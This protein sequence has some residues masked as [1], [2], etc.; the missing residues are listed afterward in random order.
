MENI[1]VAYK[2][3]N[4]RYITVSSVLIYVVFLSFLSCDFD[5]KAFRR[6]SSKNPLTPK[7][8]QNYKKW[9][10]DNIG[11][12]SRFLA[13]F[14]YILWLP[15]AKFCNFLQ[16]FITGIKQEYRLEQAARSKKTFIGHN[17]F[18]NSI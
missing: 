8:Q 17:E 6:P 14:S 2:W 9:Q 11:K 13:N 1:H 10:E 16:A 15:G 4:K 5:I 7:T 12:F 3:H 18:W